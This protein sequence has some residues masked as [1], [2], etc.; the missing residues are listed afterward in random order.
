MTH[1]MKKK[2]FFLDSSTTTLAVEFLQPLA[3]EILSNEKLSENRFAV[4]IIEGTNYGGPTISR[5]DPN[6]RIITILGDL[7]AASVNPGLVKEFTKLAMSK[8]DKSEEFKISTGDMIKNHLEYF[9]KGEYLH[10]GSFVNS[11]GRIAAVAGANGSTNEAL[12]RQYFSL[13]DL[14]IETAYRIYKEQ[15]YSLDKPLSW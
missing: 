1:R 12:A 6:P 7:D 8:F 13:E 15:G 10:P 4:L 9:Y 3:K 2:S 14:I 11:N 5:K